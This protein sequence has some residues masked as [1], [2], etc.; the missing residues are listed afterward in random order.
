MKGLPSKCRRVARLW[1]VGAALLLFGFAPST[2]CAAPEPANTPV[3]VMTYNIRNSVNDRNS[4]DNNWPARRG[5]L[6]DVVVG[7]KPDVV[8][9]QEVLPDQR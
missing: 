1:T 6:S 2:S 7:E 3:R 5:A 4:P 9:L 8:G